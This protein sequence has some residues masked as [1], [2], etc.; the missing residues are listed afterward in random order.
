MPI[1][2]QAV[3]TDIGEVFVQPGRVLAG[4]SPLQDQRRLVGDG[5]GGFGVAH[6]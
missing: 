5:Q 1:G 2:A 6:P 3:V 4:K